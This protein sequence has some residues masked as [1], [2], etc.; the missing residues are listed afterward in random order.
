MFLFR[1]TTGRC[2]LH[3]GDFRADPYMESLKELNFQAINT[4]YLDTTY[5]DKNYNFPPQQEVLAY[6]RRL[7]RKYADL[8]P[9]LLVVI[10]S[11]TIGKEKVFMAAAQELDC[12]LWAPKEKRSILNLLQDPL[13]ADRLVTDPLL[14]R[15]HVVNMADVKPGNLKKYLQSLTS[16]FSHVLALNPTGWEFDQLTG[17]LN[18]PI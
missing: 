18:F 14:A 8:Y 10:G 9:K 13:I 1:F 12:Q 3:V 2:L 5:C 16:S 7:V 15:I 11:Y 6:V 4:I 17:I